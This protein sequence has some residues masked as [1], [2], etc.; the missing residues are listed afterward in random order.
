VLLKRFCISANLAMDGTL[1]I[2]NSKD[3]SEAGP[4]AMIDYDSDS[5]VEGRLDSDL[6][7]VS[8]GD[9]SSRKNGVEVRTKSVQFSPTGRAWAAVGDEPFTPPPPP[10]PSPFL[11]TFSTPKRLRHHEP[12][13]TRTYL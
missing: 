1:S 2:L 10:P 8:K 12:S 7:G 6:P 11:P 13:P 5:D 9:F 3:M 4:L